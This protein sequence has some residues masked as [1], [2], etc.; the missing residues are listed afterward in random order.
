LSI[1][2]ETPYNNRQ[3]I[4]SP[5]AGGSGQIRKEARRELAV[6]QERTKLKAMK[7]VATIRP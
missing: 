6:M 7:P 5:N 4:L 1:T 2:E 3:L